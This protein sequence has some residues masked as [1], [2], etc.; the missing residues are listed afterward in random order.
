M[1]TVEEQIAVMQA[2]VRGEQIQI[3]SGGGEWVDVSDPS[4][5]WASIN[6]RVRPAKPF[7]CWAVVDR[8]GAASFVKTE[9][10]ANGQADIWNEHL[11]HDAPHVVIRMREVTE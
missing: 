5:N 1:K 9:E 3:L 7:E 11:K 4:F 8:H 2:F 10:V 6:Y